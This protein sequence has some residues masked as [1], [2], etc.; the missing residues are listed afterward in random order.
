MFTKLKLNTQLYLAFGAMVLLLGV[1]SVVALIALNSGYEN[2]VDYRANARDS[3]ISGRIQSNVLSLRLS[4]LKYLKDQ[5]QASI[6]EFTNRYQLL[7]DLIQSG[8][9]QFN[10]AN[11]VKAITTIEQEALTYN[12]PLKKLL[13]SLISEMKSYPT[14]LMPM[15]NICERISEII[16]LSMQK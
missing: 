3:N 7:N 4:A 9:R 1:V 12:Q 6:N 10:D 5:N 2:F 15:V 13:T 11:K 14:C 8:K 16:Q